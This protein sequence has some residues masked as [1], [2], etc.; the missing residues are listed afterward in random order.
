MYFSIVALPLH[1][2]CKGTAVGMVSYVIIYIR[3][4]A[5][6]KMDLSTIRLNS[7]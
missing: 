1:N 7:V 6:S 3:Y 2:L 4:T 5:T